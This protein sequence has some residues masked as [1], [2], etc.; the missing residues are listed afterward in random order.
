MNR[1]TI[2][3]LFMLF[4]GEDNCDELM[5]F[6]DISVMEISKIIKPDA[7][8][9]DV[10]LNFLCAANA[11][12]RYQQARSAR[13]NSE[14]TYAGKMISADNKTVVS[15]ALKLLKDYY[16]LCSDLIQPQNFIFM[17]FSSKEDI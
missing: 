10:R 3:T 7:D 16:E 8:I 13:D 5:P 11:N 14:Y 1:I 2:R 9:E 6:I 12:Y 15:Y 4:S 17:S